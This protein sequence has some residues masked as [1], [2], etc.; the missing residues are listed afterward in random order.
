MGIER[1]CLYTRFCREQGFGG[2][3]AVIQRARA[4][5]YVLDH[6]PT[7]VFDDEIVV[8]STTEHRLGAMLYPELMGMAIWPELPTIARRAE[9]PVALSDE[10]ADILADEVFPFWCDHTVHELARREGNDPESIRLSEQMVL[11][12]LARSNGVSHVIPD[13]EIVVRRGLT[14][15]IQEAAEQE[16]G[17]A[18]DEAVEFY[19]A[20]RVVLTAVI[21]FAGRYSHAC[22]ALARQVEGDRAL[23]LRHLAEILSR[24]PA[25][26]ARDLHEALQAIWLVH[27]AL[28]QE[29][30]DLALSFGR[31]DQYLWP[32]YE[33]DTAA[34]LS[35]RRASELV[36]SFFIKINDH[37]PLVPSAAR[38]IVGGAPTSQALTLGG[39][40]P[41]GSD[42]VNPLTYLLLKTA[43]ILA[44][45]EPN[46]CAR[47]HQGSSQTYRRALVESIA[48][49][50]AAP[51]LFSDEAIIAALTAH[52]VSIEHARDYG[53][54]GCVEPTSAGRTMGMTG[55]ILFNLAAVLELTLHDGVHP[56][57]GLR[58]G[59]S[60][61]ALTS[62]NSIDAFRAAFADQ[63]EA[64]VAHACDGDN[65]LA[66][67]HAERCP[68]PLLSTLVRGTSERGR[69]V[70]RGGALYNSAG[71]AVVGLADVADSLTALEQVVFAE[72]K[73]GLAELRQALGVDF[74]GH[75]K[76][77]ALLRT[78][79]A[80][81]GN[82]D[83]TA[84]EQV[85]WL[86][87]LIADLF[88][89]HES[90]F[91]GRYHLGF[92]TITLHTGFGALTGPLPSGRRRCC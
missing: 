24:V 59:P 70:T 68:T 4:L 20:T 50:G 64:L 56:L 54:V 15:L 55:A 41:T 1:A 86:V 49:T 91:G 47:L 53:L 81:Y 73:V 44:L 37:T 25:Q 38:D 84:D 92:W 65:R 7:P 83:P 30:S 9:E 82:G 40:T 3:R 42:G 79:A 32:L 72:R 78:K 90:P 87:K 21:R 71:V 31:L 76:V 88:A 80:K 69:D 35:L 16:H 67:A 11:Y 74:E 12:L 52:D 57:S 61:G 19:R 58:L 23:E 26:P 62:F 8:G 17:A 51:A 85:S 10:D 18:N 60:T 43:E 39:L 66:R 45:R 75:E 2:R 28:H 13:F 46:L 27:V 34:G 29:N 89:R 6:L 48:R 5:S 36:G 63:L 14:S 77:R 33:A 22:R